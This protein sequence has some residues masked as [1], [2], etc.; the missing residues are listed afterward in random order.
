MVNNNEFYK[1]RKV[2]LEIYD[3]FVKKLKA[4][5]L[6]DA[7]LLPSEFYQYISILLN[8]LDKDIEENTYTR[9]DKAISG[10][11]TIDKEIKLPKKIK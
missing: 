2:R 10:K 6:K 4:R 5:F 3:I 9:K 8:T 11:I 7:S 1:S